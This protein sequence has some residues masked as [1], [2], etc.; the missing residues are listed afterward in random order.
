MS[1]DRRLIDRQVGKGTSQQ[2]RTRLATFATDLQRRNLARKSGLGM[3]RAK[4]NSVE[5]AAIFRQQRFEPT[6]NVSKALEGHKSFG[7]LWPVGDRDCEQ[8]G[9]AS[10][11][12][13]SACAGNDFHIISDYG[14]LQARLLVEDA[15]AIKKYRGPG[16]TKIHNLHPTGSKI[17]LGEFMASGCAD[18][19]QI[20][21]RIVNCDPSTRRD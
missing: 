8:A 9:L 14:A 20:F 13:G 5:H 10:P 16:V 4:V 12:H 3:M 15:V 18:V 1:A 7:D 2:Q 21:R 6:Q 19:T 17:A 11:P